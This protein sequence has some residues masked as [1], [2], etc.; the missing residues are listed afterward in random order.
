MS[1]KVQLNIKV[2]KE[3]KEIIE[4]ESERIGG[5]KRFMGTYVDRVIQNEGDDSK[6][7]LERLD[8]IEDELVDTETI[9]KSRPQETQ[10]DESQ[11]ELEQKVEQG[12]PIDP[13]EHDLTQMKGSG[14]A[15]EAAELVVRHEK[16]MTEE[17]IE[18]L[19]SSMFDYSVNAARQKERL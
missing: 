17:E 16:G 8:R 1:E 11:T 15:M 5:S 13:S 12:E 19:F 3:T 2:E 14:Q 18:E 9:E 6:A 4:Q 7:I 10:T